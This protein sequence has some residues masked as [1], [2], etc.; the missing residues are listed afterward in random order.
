MVYAKFG[1]QTECNMGNWKIENGGKLVCFV[2]GWGLTYHCTRDLIDFTIAF[3]SIML[4][5]KLSLP[6]LTFPEHT[7]K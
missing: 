3:T 1:G 4:S 5:S 2:Q 6:S 7:I